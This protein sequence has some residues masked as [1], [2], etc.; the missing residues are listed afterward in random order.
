MF[1]Y[2][3]VAN[4]AQSATNA[5]KFGKKRIYKTQTC[6]T[7]HLTIA[8][9]FLCVSRYSLIFATDGVKTQG[10]KTCPINIRHAGCH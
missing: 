9:Q 3:S 1:M 6:V 7:I 2:T 10:T 5:K 4:D 8:N